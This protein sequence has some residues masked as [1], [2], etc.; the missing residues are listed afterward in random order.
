MF[1]KIG[2][3]DKKMPGSSKKKQDREEKKSP[4]SIRFPGNGY[5]KDVEG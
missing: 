1:R 3:K 4:K 5:R 2:N